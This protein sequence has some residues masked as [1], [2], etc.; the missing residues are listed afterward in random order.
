[1]NLVNNWALW[2][3]DRKWERKTNEKHERKKR[4][5]CTYHHLVLFLLYVFHLWTMWLPTLRFHIV[6]LMLINK[7]WD[8]YCWRC[9]CSSTITCVSVYASYCIDRTLVHHIA[10]ER[11]YIELDLM[12][13]CFFVSFIIFR[14]ENRNKYPFKLCIEAIVK[15][16][17]HC[18]TRNSSKGD[19]T[20]IMSGGRLFGDF[21]RCCAIV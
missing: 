6:K 16:I 5:R 11:P 15:P 3:H 7:Y 1:M 14:L 13:I 2:V 4:K 9:C 17:N 19:W 21:T 10:C 12:A 18:S 8:C 20:C